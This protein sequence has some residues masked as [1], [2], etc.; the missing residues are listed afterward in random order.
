[1]SEKAFYRKIHPNLFSDSKITKKGKFSKEFFSFFLES[2]TSQNKEKE[3]EDFCRRIVEA[4]ICPNL[5][6]Q[7]GPTGGGDS[8]VDSETYP[9]SEFIAESWLYGYNNSAHSKRWAFAI[10]AKKDWKTKLKSDV[11]KIIVTNE[12]QGRGYTRIFFITNQFISDKKR[13]EAEDGLRKEYQLDIRILD[14]TWLLEN[15]FKDD[16]QKLAISAFNMSDE[17]NDVIEEGTRD[18]QHKKQL[19]EI[20]KELQ[21]IDKLKPARIMKLAEKSVELLR[22]LEVDKSTII[23]ALERN[24]RLSRKYGGLRDYADALYNYCWTII[25]WYED[26]EI[27]YEMYVKLENLYKE[28]VDCYP[29]LRDLS[30]LWITLFSNHNQGKKI[31]A[32]MKNHTQLLIDSFNKFINDTANPKRAKLAKYDYQMMRLQNPKLWS[33]VVETYIT[34]LQDM[35]FNND[36]DLFQLKK[37]LELPVLKKC[38]KYDELFE[39]LIHLLGE[40]SKNIESSQLL[41]NRGDDYLKNNIYK[42]I[43]FYSRALTK[44]YYEDS[45]IDL[46]KT[47]MKLG[48]AFEQIG[49]LWGARCYYIRAFMD[50]LDLYFNKGDAIPGLFLSM[51]SLKY[52]EL[53]LGRINYSLQ[54]NE[55][56]LIGLNLYP[57]EIDDKKELEKYLYY[58]SLLAVALLNLKQSDIEQFEILPDYLSEKGLETA[59]AA[60]KYRLGYYDEG[61]VKAMGS[62]EALDTFMKKLFKQPASNDFH[63]VL[64]S[65]FL[66][67]KIK[68]KTTI[69]GCVETT[70][71]THFFNL[72]II[73]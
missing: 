20:E 14:R 64:N 3:F 50:S 9:V 31:I 62:N 23:N 54:F 66:N 47:L 43:K 28:N 2:L 21:N 59:S 19:S 34:I 5:L 12:E 44:L 7:T 41:L 25:W 46:I 57:Y 32:N 15:T 6:P 38:D 18:I 42:S 8:K 61:Y 4:T 60:L 27:Y 68:L 71:G 13:A 1:M 45:K 48:T 49:L 30:V 63:K 56:E 51:R 24:I 69:M 36:I 26:R 72:V 35:H 33:N 40:Q 52:L 29:I 53:R 55:L 73:M 11:K 65:D 16:N 10:S 39:L 37:I 67:E 17:L 70:I 58:D 22:E